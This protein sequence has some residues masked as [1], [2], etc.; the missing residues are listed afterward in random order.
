MR[1][2][3]AGD[4]Q[5]WEPR[6]P[7]ANPGGSPGVQNGVSLEEGADTGTPILDESQAGAPEPSLTPEL[8]RSG[9]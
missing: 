4:T 6:R 5:E 8:P 7:K 9:I 2:C 3:Q 1:V